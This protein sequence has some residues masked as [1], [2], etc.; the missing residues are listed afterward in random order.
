MDGVLM[1][2]M[3]YLRDTRR[4]GEEMVPRLTALGVL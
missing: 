3:D 1:S 4:F 2:Y